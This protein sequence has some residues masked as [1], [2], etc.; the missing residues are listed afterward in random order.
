MKNDLL[1]SGLQHVPTLFAAPAVFSE[2]QKEH[3]MNVHRCD[4]AQVNAALEEEL[5]SIHA[6][7]IKRVWTPA[8]QQAATAST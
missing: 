2:L 3:A 8:Q 4:R 7:S 5:K 6:L 1:T